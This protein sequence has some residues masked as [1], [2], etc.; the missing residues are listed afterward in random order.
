AANGLIPVGANLSR[1]ERLSGVLD[2]TRRLR[3]EQASLQQGG[4][5]VWALNPFVTRRIFILVAKQE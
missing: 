3:R 1:E 2:K 4:V 5:Y